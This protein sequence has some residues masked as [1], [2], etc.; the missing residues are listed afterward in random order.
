MT[1]VA[2]AIVLSAAQSASHAQVKS[3]FGS[4]F[5]ADISVVCPTQDGEKPMFMEATS[6]R[7]YPIVDPHLRAVAAKACETDPL[8]MATATTVPVSVTNMRSTT[9]YVSFTL[10]SGAPGPIQWATNANCTSSTGGG[11]AIA[12]GQSCSATVPA[13]SGSTRFCAALDAPPAN[14]WQ[15]Q[16]NHQTMVE[17]T[18]VPA[19]SCFPAGQPCVYYDI[20]LIP[21]NCTDSAWSLDECK[22]TGGAAYNLPVAIGCDSTTTFACMGPVSG[23]WGPEQ[24]PSNCGNPNGTCVG[25]GANCVDAYFFP[26]FSGVPAT[27]QPTGGCFKGKTFEVTWLPGS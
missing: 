21:Q 10:Q 9:I 11:L 12:A 23:H 5:G 25:T 22:D 3:G 14:C 27:H 1:L 8:H 2:A 6:G 17:T 24:Y 26:M 13:T 18:F 4:H 15:A 16:T 19:T 7:S 20:S